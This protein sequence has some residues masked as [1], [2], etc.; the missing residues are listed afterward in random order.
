MPFSSTLPRGDRRAEPG[1]TARPSGSRSD[2][3]PPV[4]CRRSR[5]G[6]PGAVPGSKPSGEGRG[7]PVPGSKRWVKDKDVAVIGG[8]RR[9]L[10]GPASEGS[11]RSGERGERGLDLATSRLQGRRKLQRLP[12]RGHRLVH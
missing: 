2:S 1:A 9:D 8:P 10:G 4:P 3:S 5:G 11:G 12:E 6:R 7:G